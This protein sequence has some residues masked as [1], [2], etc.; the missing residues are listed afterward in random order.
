MAILSNK[1][2]LPKNLS[3]VDWEIA[4]N[5]FQNKEDDHG[6]PFLDTYYRDKNEKLKNKETCFLVGFGWWCGLHFEIAP[7]FNLTRGVL[8]PFTCGWPSSLLNRFQ[9][10]FRRINIEFFF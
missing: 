3:Y 1:T 7:L 5:C 8:D 10:T 4:A 9:N 2:G 6:R